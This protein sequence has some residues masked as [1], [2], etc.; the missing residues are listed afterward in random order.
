MNK[1]LI[2]QVPARSR[3]GRHLILGQ[4]LALPQA[5]IPC[6]LGPLIS[7]IITCENFNEKVTGVRERERIFKIFSLWI[8][9]QSSYIYV[10]IYIYI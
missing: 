8:R 4:T 10:C 9:N 2:A 6:Q 3:L 5:Q 1:N 7:F